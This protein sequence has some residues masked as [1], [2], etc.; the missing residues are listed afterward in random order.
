MEKS[1]RKKH[2][3]EGLFRVISRADYFF[4][5]EGA[6][7]IITASIEPVYDM[8]ANIKHNLISEETFV[9]ILEKDI[10]KIGKAKQFR[11]SDHHQADIH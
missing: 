6:G 9:T 8:T 3:Y 7:G 4:K 10:R 5:V 1:L 2:P 11:F